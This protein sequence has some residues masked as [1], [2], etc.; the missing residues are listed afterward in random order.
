MGFK[1]CRII[2]LAMAAQANLNQGL[3]TGL[4]S[5]YCIYIAVIFWLVFNEKLKPKFILGMGLI[6]TYVILISLPSQGIMSIDFG[7]SAN[8]KAISVGLCVPVFNAMFITISRYWTLE[9]GYKSYDFTMD[10]FLLTGLVGICFFI[11]FEMTVGYSW[12]SIGYGLIAATTQII[13]TLCQIYAATYGLG[14]P[15]S[16]MI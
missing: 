15:S 13:G 12:K 10:A 16:A 3:I 1:F 2:A 8:I 14:G 11:Y 5:L 6:L 9:H 4:L 7:K